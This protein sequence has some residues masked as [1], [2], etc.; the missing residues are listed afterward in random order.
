MRDCGSENFVESILNLKLFIPDDWCEIF[1][2]DHAVIHIVEEELG[3][4]K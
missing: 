4:T 3:L 2:H 1:D